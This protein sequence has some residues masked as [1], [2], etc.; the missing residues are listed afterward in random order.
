[1]R[2]RNGE[3]GMDVGKYEAFL[4]VADVEKAHRQQSVLNML[5]RDYEFVLTVDAASGICRLYG[6]RPPLP[7]RTTY[8][9]LAASFIQPQAPSHQRTVLRRESRLENLLAHLAEQPSYTYTYTL[10]T[11]DGPRAKC[12]RCVWLDRESGT[13]LITLGDAR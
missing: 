4:R 9:A 6:D 3:R 5:A 11:A 12:L 8:R 1:M 10:E 13:L 2:K 7:D